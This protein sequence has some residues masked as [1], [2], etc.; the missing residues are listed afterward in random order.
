MTFNFLVSSY[1]KEMELKRVEK[2]LKEEY[3]STIKNLQPDEA[4]NL[5]YYLAGY[6]MGVNKEEMIMKMVI[7][8]VQE[9]RDQVW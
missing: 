8:Q 7:K 4:R 5:I 9:N 6:A 2:D 1:I 3:H